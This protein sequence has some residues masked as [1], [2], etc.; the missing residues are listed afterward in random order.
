MIKYIDNYQYHTFLYNTNYK[1][2]INN[3]FDV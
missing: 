3:E 1:L 2:D